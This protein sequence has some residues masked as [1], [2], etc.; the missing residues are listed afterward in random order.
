MAKLDQSQHGNKASTF[1]HKLTLFSQASD[2]KSP[3]TQLPFGHFGLSPFR[4][5]LRDRSGKVRKKSKFLGSTLRKASFL[6][7]AEPYDVEPAEGYKV[8]LFPSNNAT[9]KQTYMGLEI[10]DTPLIMAINKAARNCPGDT[11]HFLDIGGNSGMY[12]IAAAQ[13]ARKAG[14]RIS[15]VVIEANPDMVERL[16][17]NLEA[18][19]VENPTIFAFA[20]SD[21]NTQVYLSLAKKNLGQA[22]LVRTPDEGHTIFVHAR[23]LKD[24]LDEANMTRIDF[25]KID[26]EGH[27]VPALTPYFST[28]I[29][30]R[31]PSTILAEVAHDSEHELVKLLEKYRYSKIEDFCDDAIFERVTE[32]LD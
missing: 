32:N 29:A 24:M 11:F 25:L 3:S 23:L 28:E 2:M 4:N 26:I 22:K 13:A 14:K 8:R 10:T 6:G 9:D 16:R 21:K 19:G 27:E 15:L 1:E 31:Y 17:F 5:N 7:H 12:S 18:S 30:S 20:A